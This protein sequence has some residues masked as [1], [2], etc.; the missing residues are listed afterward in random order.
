MTTGLASPRYV[1]PIAAIAIGVSACGGSSSGSAPNTAPTPNSSAG[2]STP[3][4]QSV[5]VGQVTRCQ[6]VL[7]SAYRID[8]AHSGSVSATTYSAAADVQAALE[9]DQLKSGQRAVYLHHTAGR[10]DGVASCVT[11]T[12]GSAHNAQR[13]LGSYKALRKD[14]GKLAK[15]ITVKGNVPAGT[16]GYRE[17][18]QSF[19][20]YQIS[21]TTVIEEAAVTGSTLTITSTAD[22]AASVATGAKLLAAVGA[23]A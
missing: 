15:P 17:L 9:Y 12:F 14:A 11:L 4:A 13:F 5:A 3:T 16:V 20:G 23:S 8:S 19:S 1:L 7:P 22:R 18:D 10:V 2:A 6:S 21:S